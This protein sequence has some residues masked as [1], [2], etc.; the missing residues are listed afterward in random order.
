MARL[1]SND[2]IQHITAAVEANAHIWPTADGKW[3][4]KDRA[5]NIIVQGAES[6]SECA[7]QFVEGDKVRRFV[8]DWF[9]VR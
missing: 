7:R 6:M 4:A 1:G 2:R 8:A 3:L 9:G 5:G